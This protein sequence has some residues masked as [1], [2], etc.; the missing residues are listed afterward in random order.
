M[1]YIYQKPLLKVVKLQTM[2]MLA[3]S[4]KEGEVAEFDELLAPEMKFDLEDDFS[5]D[6]YEVTEE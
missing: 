1:K 2:Q 6:D 5:T 3:V 4:V